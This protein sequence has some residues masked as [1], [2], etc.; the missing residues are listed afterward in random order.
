MLKVF[1]V[2]PSP[3][4]PI[5][6]GGGGGVKTQKTFNIFN[7]FNISPIL[8]TFFVSNP[9]KFLTFWTFPQWEGF[10]QKKNPKGGGGQDP[11]NF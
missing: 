2:L 10:F 5:F 6:W 4:P 7:I 8:S 1:W 3:L 9:F 11:E